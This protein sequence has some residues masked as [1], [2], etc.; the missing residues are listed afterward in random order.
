MRI[1]I[2]PT[3]TDDTHDRTGIDA[4]AHEPEAKYRKISAVVD[5]GP[6]FGGQQ[7]GA[8]HADRQ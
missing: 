3:N 1:E 7:A 2:A 6:V 5:Y 4:S 8:P